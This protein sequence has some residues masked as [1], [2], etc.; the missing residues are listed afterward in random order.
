LHW[1]EAQIHGGE[2]VLDYGCGSGILAIAAALLGASS[3]VGTD[4]GPQAIVASRANAQAN[5]VRVQFVYV[6]ALADARYAR[7]VANILAR[8]LRILAPA[9]AARTAPGGRI[10]LS[11]ILV[12]QADGVTDAYAR[13]FDVARWRT[14]DGWVLLDGTRRDEV[15]AR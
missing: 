10:A 5:G 14:E 3:V 15:S 8:P 2:R 7:V 9:L 4:I 13:W 11:G 1:L 6:D 12:D